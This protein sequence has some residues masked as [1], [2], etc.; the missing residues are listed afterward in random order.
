MSA[1][2]WAVKV[3]WC[4]CTIHSALVS[5]SYTPFC[6]QRD[7][8]KP[9]IPSLQITQPS[10]P[11]LPTPSQQ[12]FLSGSLWET[13]QTPGHQAGHGLALTD[14]PSLIPS[15]NLTGLAFPTTV[16]LGAPSCPNA[17]AHAVASAWDPLRSPLSHLSS[18]SSFGS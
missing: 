1:L 3:S 6:C 4:L 18:C 15:L 16:P 10:L 17:C 13:S 8:F 5:L 2:V 12:Q 14:L 9:H 11:P 7:P